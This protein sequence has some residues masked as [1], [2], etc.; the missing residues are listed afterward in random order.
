MEQEACTAAVAHMR[1]LRLKR[2]P[3]VLKLGLPGIQRPLQ[4]SK[5]APAGLCQLLR[6]LC[7]V[8]GCCGCCLLLLCLSHQGV[9]LGQLLGMPAGD[10]GVEDIT[11]AG[12][13]LRKRAGQSAAENLRRPRLPA[14]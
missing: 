13:G 11:N 4:V 3:A 12:Q 6:A 2:L 8:G 7:L 5:H 10:T 9:P 14:A 1:Q